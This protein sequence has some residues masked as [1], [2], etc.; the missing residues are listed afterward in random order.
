MI[1]LLTLIVV[2]LAIIAIVR[3][4]RILELVNVLGGHEEEYITDK[5]NKNN[6]ILFI[7]FMVIGFASMIYFTID[8]KKYLLPVAAT[9]HGV[10]TDSYLNINFALI[11]VVFFI[12]EILLFYYAFKY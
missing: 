3:I 5:D 10:L 8:A 12:T 4:V 11:A 2:V 9:K 6:G 1:S 7:L